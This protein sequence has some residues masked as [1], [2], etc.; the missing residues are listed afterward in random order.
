VASDTEH[1]II[2]G[3]QSS[4]ATASMAA[5]TSLVRRPPNGHTGSA[6]VRCVEQF[7]FYTI[8][9]LILTIHHFLVNVRISCDLS[10]QVPLLPLQ[11]WISTISEI[12]P[13]FC[14]IA[15]RLRRHQVW[16]NQHSLC[17]FH[18]QT[19]R[20]TKHT[21]IHPHP[22]LFWINTKLLSHELSLKSLEQP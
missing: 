13:A 2:A 3:A 20:K 6:C 21:P 15:L 14:H 1:V 10:H 18:T 5:I 17:N 19:N 4:W 7:E 11:C 16:N 22:N 12:L 9:R 8:K